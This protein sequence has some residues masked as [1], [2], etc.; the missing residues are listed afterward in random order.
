MS[1]PPR[2]ELLVVHHSHGW[3]T[4]RLADAV[5]AGALG[6][7]AVGVRSL[8]AGRATLE[9]LLAADG[10]LFGTPETFGS[11]CGLLKDFFERT[12]YPALGRLN[13]RPFA[14]FVCAGN[15]GSGAVRS[16]QRI[17]RGHGW[18]EVQPALVVRS[19]E[20]E[21]RVNDCEELGAAMALGLAL[22]VF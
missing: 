6:T 7:N 13:G 22:G 18:R 8:H 4:T 14:L 16:I 12:Y 20:V 11:M 2:P 5:V 3:R 21:L 17:A 15:D 9:D 1:G 19:E 10:Y